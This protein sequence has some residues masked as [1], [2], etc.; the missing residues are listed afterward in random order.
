[1]WSRDKL[2]TMNLH[3]HNAYGQQTSQGGDIRDEVFKNGSS[4]ICGRRP[5]K[6]FYLVHSLI[7]CLIHIARSSHSWNDVVT[8]GHMTNW[9]NYIST[10]WRVMFTKL[11]KLLTWK[12]RFRMQTPNSKRLHVYFWDILQRS[13]L[14]VPGFHLCGFLETF[15]IDVY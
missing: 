6:K 3:Y 4:K 12:R 11:G 7:H 10:F 13:Q 9:K 2:K 14:F 8:W 5:L 1:M 15:W